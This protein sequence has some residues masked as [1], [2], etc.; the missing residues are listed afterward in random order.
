MK[1]IIFSLAAVAAIAGIVIVQNV[2]GQSV[3]Q[4]SGALGPRYGD[5]RVFGAYSGSGVSVTNLHSA[6]TNIN[7][8]CDTRFETQMPLQLEYDMSAG[9]ATLT[10]AYGRSIDDGYSY[11][12][13]KRYE[14]T[15]STLA[16]APA[17]G[18]NTIFTNILTYGAASI[19]LYYLTNNHA[20]AD[21]TNVV[22]KYGVQTLASPH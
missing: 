1:K 15:L 3:G 13:G 19:Q 21:C 7:A 16:I 14:T 4:G 20:S 11:G 5:V 12:S 22:I 10:L 6:A 8:Q 17:V 9:S 2:T 18:T